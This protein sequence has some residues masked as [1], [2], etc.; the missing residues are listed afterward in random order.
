[1]SIGGEYTMKSTK[2]LTV[3]ALFIATFIVVMTVTASFSFG[4]VQIRIVN[5]LYAV[6]YMFPF[7]VIPTGVA[8]FLSN[9]LYG[10]MGVP[11]L[12][13]GFLVGIVT[14]SLVVLVRKYKL[15][16]YLVIIPIILIPALGV[17]MWLSPLI[18]VPYTALAVSI[19][20]GQVI[21]AIVG[22]LLVKILENKLK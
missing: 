12:V 14:T 15:P 9:L 17:P 7:L 2:K 5:A 4:A 21:P 8:V 19:G 3:S 16:K 18:G 20:L 1:M 13:G 22:Y 6:P 11:D 10:G